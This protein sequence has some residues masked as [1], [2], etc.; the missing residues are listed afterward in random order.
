MLKMLSDLAERMFIFVILP[1]SII[2]CWVFL[3]V[4]HENT[5]LLA[6]GGIV[7]LFG[8]TLYGASIASMIPGLKRLGNRFDNTIHRLD[9][10]PKIAV[11]AYV[12]ILVIMAVAVYQVS[13]TF[14]M[15]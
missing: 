2:G 11:P 10:R 15:P 4:Y 8:S 1:V 13:Q 9:S 5:I 14:P 7:L 3:I 6:S 12:T